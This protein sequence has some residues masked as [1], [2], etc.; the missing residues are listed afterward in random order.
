MTGRV[1]EPLTGRRD[2]KLLCFGC[3][4]S[5]NM[6]RARRARAVGLGLGPPPVE[7]DSIPTQE[8]EQMRA[9][10][11]RRR[12]TTDAGMDAASCRSERTAYAFIP[13]LEAN[14]ATTRE[15]GSSLG[16]SGSM[17]SVELRRVHTWLCCRV[18]DRETPASTGAGERD[19]GKQRKRTRKNARG[20][21][22]TYGSCTAAPRTHTE[23]RTGAGL[24]RP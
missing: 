15:N 10:E 20:R 12:G 5:S 19:C 3:G 22:L 1:V 6:P 8:R 4:I 16:H 7:F 13:A 24:V 18:S 14:K 11:V 17:P 21:G 9:A 2:D 23:S